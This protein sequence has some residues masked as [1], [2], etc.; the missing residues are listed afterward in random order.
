MPVLTKFG[1]NLA[2]ARSY[3]TVSLRNC[4]LGVNQIV[5]KRSKIMI[6]ELRIPAQQQLATLKMAVESLSCPVHRLFSF[7]PTPPSLHTPSISLRATCNQPCLRISSSIHTVRSQ[8]QGGNSGKTFATL[9][10]F[11]LPMSSQ[12]SYLIKNSTMTRKSAI[13]VRH[14]SNWMLSSPTLI[15]PTRTSPPKVLPG[16]HSPTRPTLIMISPNIPSTSLYWNRIFQTLQNSR[17]MTP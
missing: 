6:W 8:I 13:S 14:L 15:L 17:I 3:R 11:N 1:C 10:P 12:P 16:L 2:A 4:K 9:R 5:Q 7:P